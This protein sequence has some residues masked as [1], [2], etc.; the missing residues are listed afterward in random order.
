MTKK[1]LINIPEQ[2]ENKLFSLDDEGKS[3]MGKVIQFVENTQNFISQSPFF[4]PEYT[5]HSVEH[6]NNALKISIKLIPNETMNK[7]SADTIAILIMAII[8]HDIGM[9]IKP[10]GLENLLKQTPKNGS[11]DKSWI[12]EWKKYQTQLNHFSINEIDKYFGNPSSFTIDDG[13]D[14]M[15]LPNEIT[16]GTLSPWRIRLCGEFLRRMHPRLAQEIIEN[17]FIGNEQVDL[18]S[19]IE[20]DNEYRKLIGIVARSHGMN[21]NGLDSK[22]KEFDE[23]AIEYPYEVPIYYL[24]AILRLADY[25]DAGSDRAPHAIM[26]MQH[27][28]AEISYDEFKWNQTVN[29]GN[30][31]G[32]KKHERVFVNV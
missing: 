8:T 29:L 15:Q 16:V 25:F 21:I 30:D 6:I 4:F 20:I 7:L 32:E 3:W 24:M 9:F 31:W 19:N 23:D 17:G 22:L 11:E 27:F 10:E 28:E 14:M 1:L 13:L 18:F 12:A 2:F 5:K 26:A